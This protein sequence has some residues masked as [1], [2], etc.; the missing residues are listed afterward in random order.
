MYKRGDIVTV[1]FPFADESRSKRRPALIISNNKVNQTGDF[2]MMQITSK[3]RNDD[4]TLAIETENFS[5]KPL[6]LKSYL[7]C[8]KIFLLNETLI[9]SKTTS[10][11]ISFIDKVVDKINSL[12]M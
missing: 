4:L 12:I 9:L 8:Q 5:E 1:P 6:P 2:L 11:K 3:K 10:V 7:R